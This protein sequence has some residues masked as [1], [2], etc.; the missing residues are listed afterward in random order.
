M[1]KTFFGEHLDR[2]LDDFLVLVTL[3]GQRFG[4]FGVNETRHSD[5]PGGL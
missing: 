4:A 3:F 2:R 5:Y 1:V